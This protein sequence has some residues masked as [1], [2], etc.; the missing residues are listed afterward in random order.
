MSTADPAVRAIER[1]GPA[2][3]TGFAPVAEVPGDPGQMHVYEHGWQS[4]SPTGRYPATGTSP[5]PQRA[6]WHRMC[7]RHD[8]DLPA[9][10]FQGEGLLA[11][12]SPQGPVVLVATEDPRGHVP[13]IRAE[14]HRDRIVVTADG[15]VQVRRDLGDDL[16]DALARWAEE[17]AHD[18]AVGPPVAHDPVWCSWYCHWAEVTTA[19]IDAALAAIAEVAL[20]VGVVQIDDGHQAAIGDWLTE[21]PGFGPPGARRALA[22][23]IRAHGHRAGLWLA[24]LMAAR[25]SATA[26]AHPEWLVGDAHAGHHWGDEIAALDVTHPGAAAHLGE[27]IATVVDEGYDYL[28]LD[29]LYAGAIEG[30][31]HGDASALDA[32]GE[33]LRIIREAAGPEVTLLGCGAPQLPSIGLLDPMR[34]SPDTDPKDQP[35]DGDRSQPSLSAALA[36]GRARAFTH[37]R[38]WTA[39]PDCLLVRS[40]VARPQE[41]AEHVRASGG[42]VADSDPLAELDDD[43]LARLRSLLRPSTTTPVGWDPEGSE[44][45]RLRPDQEQGRITSTEE[46]P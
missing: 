3:G 9:T 21:R 22:Q 6:N 37:A 26:R 25:G 36:T 23:R 14:A 41:W 8:R 17:V 28:K 18:L 7:Y 13:S 35:E 46:R 19:D 16:P 29:F 2:T 5:R 31:R 44:Q 24:P 43:E 10:G 38:W 32:Y 20:P 11:V 15:P 42:L 1:A 40:E 4:W 39:D 34:I 30:R 12:A 33:A 45:G 27:V